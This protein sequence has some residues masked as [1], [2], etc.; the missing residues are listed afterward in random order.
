MA[1]KLPTYEVISEDERPDLYGVMREL[2]EDHH[3]ELSGAVVQLVWRRNWKGDKDQR[4]VLGQAIIPSRVD[5]LTHGIDLRILLNFEVYNSVQFSREQQM[6][7]I[8]HEL[9]H[10]AP[11]L[12][13]DTMEQKV[14]ADGL[15]EWRKRK[16]NLE[17]FREIVARHGQ[18]KSDIQDFVRVAMEAGIPEQLTLADREGS[19]ISSVTFGSGPGATTITSDELESWRKP[20]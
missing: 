19:G 4:L 10:F 1:R 5:R 9:Q 14:G 7:L 12:D 18:W 2:L 3:D 16:H 13:E 11:A 20:H 17:E 8:D 15:R 6:A